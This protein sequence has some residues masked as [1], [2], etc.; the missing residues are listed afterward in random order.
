MDMDGYAERG[1]SHSSEDHSKVQKMGTIKL[2][3][4]SSKDS[5]LVGY[6]IKKV[7]LEDILMKG[8]ALPNTS[9]IFYQPH[10]HGRQRKR[11]KPLIF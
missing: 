3:Y 6:K 4:E 8:R 10:S 7:T 9:S 1:R 2:F 11:G 5:T